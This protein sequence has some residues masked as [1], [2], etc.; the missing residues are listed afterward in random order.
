MV[1][2]RDL[3]LLPELNV[4]LLTNELSHKCRR[5]VGGC[6]TTEVD[7]NR[8]C[9]YP[10]HPKIICLEQYLTR[11]CIHIINRGKKWPLRGLCHIGGPITLEPV[12][13]KLVNHFRTGCISVHDLSHPERNVFKYSFSKYGYGRV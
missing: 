7:Y 13:K 4:H 8:L 11:N 6:N 3:L 9:W 12:N 10:I 2:K 5:S 1:R